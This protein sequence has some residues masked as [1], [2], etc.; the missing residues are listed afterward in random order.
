MK[1]GKKNELS[2]ISFSKKVILLTCLNIKE[3][4][5]QVSAGLKPQKKNINLSREIF[6]QDENNSRII[7]CI[8]TLFSLST[9][10][11]ACCAVVSNVF[12]P[13]R[14]KDA[15]KD[16]QK[17]LKYDFCRYSKRSG[18]HSFSKLEHL[19]WYYF[20]NFELSKHL[21]VFFLFFF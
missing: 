13:N 2:K 20:T 4:S 11:L 3:R 15:P 6:A 17:I 16:A 5:Y 14:N 12:K 10:L 8:F 7:S 18:Y 21:V 19:Q 9:C 1:T